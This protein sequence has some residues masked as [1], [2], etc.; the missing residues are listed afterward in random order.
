LIQK[1]C[2]HTT[3][4]NDF[5][6]LADLAQLEY[7]WHQAYYSA[8]DPN[9]DFTAFEQYSQYAEQL[10]FQRSHALSVL[11]TVYPILSIWQNHQNNRST[12]TVEA[13]QHADFLCIYRH[14]QQIAICRIDAAIY[15]FLRDCPH[16]SL[17]Q[18]A[19]N[20]LTAQGLNHLPH[21]I[22]QKWITAVRQGVGHCA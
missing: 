8:D 15:Q 22:N 19:Q 21:L 6:Y 7:Q 20:T 12:E 10:F 1:Q 14:N 5:L 13:L 18:L 11:E 3:Q 2:Q 9:F 17:A 4:L 16:Y